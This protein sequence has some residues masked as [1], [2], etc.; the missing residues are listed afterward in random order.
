MYSKIN[1]RNC[2]QKEGIAI[3]ACDKI[4]VK[5]TYVRGEKERHFTLIKGINHQEEI[6]HSREIHTRHRYTRFHKTH[7]LRF[8]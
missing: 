2:F 4:D 6:N 5:S 3:L 8:T 1:G 7:A